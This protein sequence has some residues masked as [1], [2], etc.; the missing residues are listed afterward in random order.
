M[1]PLDRPVDQTARGLAA[2]SNGATSDGSAPTE[3]SADARTTEPAPQRRGLDLSVP[4]IVGGALA[5]ASAAV[6]SSELGVAGTAIGAVL[7]SVVI[8]VGTALYTRPIERTSQVLRET[9]PVR[10][11][12][13][14][15]G[16]NRQELAAEPS[17]ATSVGRQPAQ[18]VRRFGRFDGVG[19]SRRALWTAIAVSTLATLVLAVALLTGLEQVTGKPVSSWTGHGADSGT[20][21]GRIF[22]S[23]SRSSTG[24]APGSRNAQ[25]QPLN[26]SPQPPSPT[27]TVTVPTT[28]AASSPAPSSPAPST[29][30]PTSPSPST[31]TATTT[32]SPS[33]TSAPSPTSGPKSDRG[34]PSVG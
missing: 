32:T 23:G 24:S 31:P 20:T 4:R 28:P 30:A 19:V 21:L 34:A 16:S 1:S 27:V 15:S 14:R 11:D 7:A 5:A 26:P 2:G 10:V 13:S 25:Q 8:S 6:A 18:A 17:G 22:N 33:P 12:A 3:T 9:L 29:T